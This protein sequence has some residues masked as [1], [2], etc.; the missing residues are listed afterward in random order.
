MSGMQT[1]FH[2]PYVDR[3]SLVITAVGTMRG[4]GIIRVVVV[5]LVLVALFAI[6]ILKNVMSIT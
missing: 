6:H 5:G 1:I 2:M 4:Q 3:F